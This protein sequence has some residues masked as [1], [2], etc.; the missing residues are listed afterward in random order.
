MDAW[1][2]TYQH[3]LPGADPVLD[4]ISGT[5]LR[6]MLDRL[7]QDE[8]AAFRADCAALLR[9]AYPR[10][11]YGTLFPFRRIFVVARKPG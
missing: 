2:T 11:P 9:R 10:R 7:D 6:P 5:A 1:E 4:W 8:R 3:V